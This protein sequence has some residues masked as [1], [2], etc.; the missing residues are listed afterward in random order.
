M[1]NFRGGELSRWRIFAV[2]F[3]VDFPGDNL[4]VDFAVENLR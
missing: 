4:A 3:P 2:D 1:E